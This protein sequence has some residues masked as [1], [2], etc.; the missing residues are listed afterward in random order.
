MIFNINV[1]TVEEPIGTA[2]VEPFEGDYS[3]VFY[4]RPGF[5]LSRGIREDLEERLKNMARE[6]EQ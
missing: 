1:P 5:A 4:I 6:A 2:L 3:V